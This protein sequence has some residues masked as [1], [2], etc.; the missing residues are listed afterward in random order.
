[1]RTTWGSAGFA[2][3]FA[4]GA[5]LVCVANTGAAAAL[6]AAGE[7]PSVVRAVVSCGGRPDLAGD[8][9]AVVQAPT[10][11][12]VGSADTTVL[13]LNQAALAQMHARARL[14]RVPGATH[15][16]EE[17]GALDEVASLA[18]SWFLEHLAAVVRPAGD[19]ARRA[20]IQAN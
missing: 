2:E 3:P 17:Q 19:S 18:A 5:D 1:M 11:F 12:I 4:G 13:R 10:L 20:T 7:R 9:L 6:S 16:F 8:A 14:A 15:L